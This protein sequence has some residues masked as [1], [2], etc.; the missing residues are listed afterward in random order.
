M[1]PQ[2]AWDEL[3]AAYVAAEWDRVEVLA[4]GLQSWLQR[5]GFPPRATAGSDLGTDWDRTIA[6]AGCRFALARAGEV[7]THDAP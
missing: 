5:G 6:L 2:T 3:L 7:L 4:D 1:D